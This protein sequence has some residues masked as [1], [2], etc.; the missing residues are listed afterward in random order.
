MTVDHLPITIDRCPS[1]ILLYYYHIKISRLYLLKVSKGTKYL[2]Y[3]FFKVA[4]VQLL[5]KQKVA[6]KLRPI[7]AKSSVKLP[8]VLSNLWPNLY[9]AG[10]SCS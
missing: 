9:K 4:V 1:I 7:L 10:V 5:N 2:R 3:F 8:L 6:V